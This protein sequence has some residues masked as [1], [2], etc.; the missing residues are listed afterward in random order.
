MLGL[1]TRYFLDV[2]VEGCVETGSFELSLS[3]L[4]ESL[5]VE[6]ILEVL[7][8]EGVLEDVGY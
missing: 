4:C 5:P 1:I 3:E 6:V 8:G 2:G 7:E